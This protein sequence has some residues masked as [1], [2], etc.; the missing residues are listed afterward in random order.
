MEFESLRRRLAGRDKL[1]PLFCSAEQ[2]ISK[3]FGANSPQEHQK[4]KAPL[5]GAFCFFDTPVVA[6]FARFPTSELLPRFVCTT[7]VLT[8][9]AL[10]KRWS[11]WKYSKPTVTSLLIFVSLQQPTFKNFTDLC[12]EAA[13]R[14]L[15]SFIRESL[16]HG[17]ILPICSYSTLY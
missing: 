15:P 11:T 5:E 10:R 14:L 3:L 2:I 4:Q 9:S 1:T 7:V 8:H 16:L 17:I 12:L 13:P 6:N